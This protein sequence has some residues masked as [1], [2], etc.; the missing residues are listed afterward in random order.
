MENPRRLNAAY[1]EASRGLSRRRVLFLSE[2]TLKDMLMNAQTP[3]VRRQ[4][5]IKDD[6]AD[7]LGQ[8]QLKSQAGDDLPAGFTSRRAKDRLGEGSR[9]IFSHLEI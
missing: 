4:T 7:V 8:R 1:V 6:D 2:E 9:Y 5:Q 3:L